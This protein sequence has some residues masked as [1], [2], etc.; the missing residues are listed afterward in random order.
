MLIKRMR[1]RAHAVRGYFLILMI[2]KDAIR[3]K[4]N[5]IAIDSVGNPGIPPDGAGSGVGVGV[6]VGVGVGVGV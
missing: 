3:A 5:P 6:V 1:S 4:T 2:I